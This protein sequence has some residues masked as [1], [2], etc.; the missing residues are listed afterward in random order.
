MTRDSS[1]PDAA[2]A[3]GRGA[4]P[5]LGGEQELDLVARRRRPST[6]ARRRSTATATVAAAHGEVRP[7]RR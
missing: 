1:P 6:P 5:G 4:A 3:T 2:L 7:A